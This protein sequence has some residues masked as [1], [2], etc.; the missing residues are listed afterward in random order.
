MAT[1]AWLQREWLVYWGATS[2][3][4]SWGPPLMACDHEGCVRGSRSLLQ[5][6]VGATCS[7]GHFA[8]LLCQGPISL[9]VG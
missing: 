7:L 2:G 1:K 3:L 5:H 4:C 8:V 9:V 6:V